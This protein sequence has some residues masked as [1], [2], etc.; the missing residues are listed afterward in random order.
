MRSICDLTLLLALTAASLCAQQ[1]EATPPS[2]IVRTTLV[3]VP[4]W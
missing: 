2:L 1:S 3:M 4:F